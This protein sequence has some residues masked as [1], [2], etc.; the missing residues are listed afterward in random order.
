MEKYAVIFPGQGVQ[1]S[2]MGKNIYEKYGKIREIYKLAGKILDVDI[3]NICFNGTQEELRLT[4]NAQPAILLT[5]YASYLAMLEEIQC[6]PTIMMGH[7]LGEITALLA[8]G[9]MK[10]EDAL[11]LVKARAMAMDRA[12]EMMPGAMCAVMTP[13]IEK[14]ETV[15]K[16]IKKSGDYVEIA[17]YNTLYQTV[18]SGTETAIIKASEIFNTY[19]IRCVRLNVQGAFHSKLMESAVEE[20]VATA[21]QISFKE[22]D[23]DVI[24][25]VNTEYYSKIE[26]IPDNIGK[27]IISPVC[28]THGL[29]KIKLEG[30]TNIIDVGPGNVVANMVRKQEWFKNVMSVKENEAEIIRLFR[31][32]KKKNLVKKCLALAVCTPNFNSDAAEYQSGVILPYKKLSELNEKLLKEN[33]SASKQE[34]AEAVKLISTIF[35]TKKI[36]NDE[37]NRRMS[38][39]EECINY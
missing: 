38:E 19:N 15:C 10:F 13:N 39:I 14:I 17:N 16:K 2:G 28:W 11:G 6:K 33:R 29:E 25:N 24:S 37:R 5:S 3:K 4:Q 30:I 35:D 7:S 21:N 12:V 8:A 20:L 23:I 27:Q 34:E 36:T 26:N 31:E 22:S 18:I 1:F 9:I 32:P